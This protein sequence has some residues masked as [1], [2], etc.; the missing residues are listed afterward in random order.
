LFLVCAYA[1]WQNRRENTLTIGV[2]KM[3]APAL[4]VLLLLCLA[5]P[6]AGQ[7]DEWKRYQNAEG[8]FSML[9]PTEPTDTKNKSEEG[10][11]SHTLL[12]TVRPN[13]YTVVYTT[14]TQEQTVNDSTYE[15]FK[16]AVFKELPKCNV[17]TDRTGSHAIQGYISHEYRLSCEMN[18]T[19]TI[20][21]NLYWGRHYSYAVM[22]MF[23]SPSDPPTIKK[24]TDSFE[25]TDTGK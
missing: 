19:V 8:N 2:L 7:T 18:V 11:Q 21:G 22:V 3:R 20:V 24:F 13:I 25:I 23:A 6:I 17:I 15:T 16:N 5:A 4:C 9:F 14:M 10:I 12:S 1:L